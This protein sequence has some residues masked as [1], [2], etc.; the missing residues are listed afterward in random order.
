MHRCTKKLEHFG[1]VAAQ[2]RRHD[3]AI[4][5]YST[6][7]S[8]NPVPPKD[9]FMKRCDAYMAKGFWLDAIHDAEQVLADV[10]YSLSSLTKYHHQVITL[11]PS[12]PWGYERKHAAL[13]GA[14]L[15]FNAIGSF[16]MM[17]LMISQSP[18][19]KIRRK[20][21]DFSPLFIC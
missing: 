11:D 4:A 2:A 12:Y 7:L 5:Q 21:I 17:L 10:L 15:Y 18:D 16:K 9:V 1:D 20:R 14:G 8:L 19:P 6:A 3:E 13:H